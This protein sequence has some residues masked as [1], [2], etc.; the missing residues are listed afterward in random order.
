MAGNNNIQQNTSLESLSIEELESIVRQDFEFGNVDQDYLFKVLDEIAKRRKEAG[1]AKDAQ[2]AWS[3]FQEIYLNS[4]C[5]LDKDCVSAHTHDKPLRKRLFMALSKVA[6]AAVLA[7]VLFGV[8]PTTIGAESLFTVV[9]RWTESLLIFDQPGGE[10]VPEVTVDEGEILTGIEQLRYSA[11]MI[12]SQK[13]VPTWLP[14]E[15]VFDQVFIT[16]SKGYITISARFASSEKEIMIQ[17]INNTENMETSNE[18]DENFL[19]TRTVDDIQHYIFQNAES[20]TCAWA[21]ENVSCSVSGDV[22]LTDM[23]KIID[24]IYMED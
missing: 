16:A 2:A 20:Y 17:Y 15:F 23:Y 10:T 13:I 5:D 1:K 4:D 9:A 24:S 21:L 7:I 12:T 18:K 8:I 22:S 11:K 19:E 6:V 14:E 3:E